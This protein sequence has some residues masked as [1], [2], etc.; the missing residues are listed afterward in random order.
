[1]TDLVFLGDAN[2]DG[3]GSSIKVFLKDFSIYNGALVI[4]GIDADDCLANCRML[5][6]NAKYDYCY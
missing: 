6:K 4:G 2:N 5:S 3:F 1:M